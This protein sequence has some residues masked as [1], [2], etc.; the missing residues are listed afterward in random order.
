VDFIL[1]L[2]GHGAAMS[3]ILDEY[4]GLTQEDIQACLLFA[5][6]VLEDASF[7]PLLGETA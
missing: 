1:A 6:K 3:D 2:L 4:P 7:V 5:G